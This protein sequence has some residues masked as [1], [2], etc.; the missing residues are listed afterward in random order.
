MQRHEAASKSV[1]YSDAD[2]DGNYNG[3]LARIAK[4]ITI[5][6]PT[7][8]TISLVDKATLC[9][10]G[11]AEICWDA[12]HCIPVSVNPESD[13]TIA[14]AADS[15]VE[16]GSVSAS[17]ASHVVRHGVAVGTVRRHDP[18]RFCAEFHPHSIGPGDVSLHRGLSSDLHAGG[19][20]DCG[21]WA[22]AEGPS[23]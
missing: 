16:D 3:V 1:G 17:T 11:A 5:K 8:F 4:A 2:P 21:V 9:L 12:T 10:Q 19:L 13:L 15:S 7:A 6:P 18:H 14:V 20:A 23:R 22:C